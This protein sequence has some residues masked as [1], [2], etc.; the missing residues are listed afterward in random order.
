MKVVNMLHGTKPHG[1]AEKPI[2]SKNVLQSVAKVISGNILVS[3]ITGVSSI[4]IA[5][6][7][8]PFDMGIWN[9]AMLVTVYSPTLQLGVFNGLNRE[10]AFAW[11]WILAG[12]SI[13][14]GAVVAF[15]YRAQPAL[16]WTAISIAVTIVCSWP[17]LYLTTTYRT[18]TEFGRLARNSVV[19]AMIG[20]ALVLLVWRFRYDGLII[21]AALLSVLG[22]VALYYRRPFPVN[23]SWGKKQFLE[24]AKVGIPIWLV[25]QLGSFFVSMD[26][27]VLLRTTYVLGYYTIAIQVG[28]FVR[29][30]PSAFSVVLYPQ[31]AHRYGETRC[32]MDVWRVARNGGI[33]ASAAGCAAGFCGWILLPRFVE[34][35]L[36]RYVSGIRA[37]QWS[38]FLGLAMGFYIFDNV[39]NVIKRQDLYLINWAI[40]A[41]SFL[42]V[43]YVLAIFMHV[44][45]AVASAQ[46]MLVATF[47]MAV[48]SAFVSRKAC[49]LHD[50]KEASFGQDATTVG[51]EDDR[52]NGPHAD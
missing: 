9:S 25:G 31:M 41:S 50:L 43:W 17:T 27:L 30:I 48:A 37:A 18:H 1:S 35:A 23:P 29:M 21:R 38:C 5:R 52:L 15:H 3:F 32:A 28:S 20:A 47:L 42:A 16:C 33:F 6:W 7:V 10:A 13:C 45:P 4:L 12:I 34:I 19:V 49:I 39:Y 14:G 36:P 11:V 8:S 51:I 40:G 46:S 44:S 22:V 24:L 2:R 26:R